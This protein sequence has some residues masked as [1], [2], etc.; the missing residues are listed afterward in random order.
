M[1]FIII[2]VLEISLIGFDFKMVV[3]I[4]SDIDKWLHLTIFID[5]FG[6]QILK[7]ILHEKE[8][9]PTDGKQLF[10]LMQNYQ[11][12]M[13]FRLHEEVLDPNDKIIDESQFGLS[14]YAAVLSLL[15]H[16]KYLEPIKDIRDMRNGVFHL[17]DELIRDNI[18]K[19]IT[20]N[21]LCMLRKYGIDMQPNALKSWNMY[22]F[23]TSKGMQN[24]LSF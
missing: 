6:K 4:P 23:D 2:L 3:P 8:Q 16:G 5:T 20:E 15:F 18:L 13:L 19:Q 7:N 24:Y 17:K 22:Q 11:H 9:L 10:Y 14:V 21:A 12:K 1:F